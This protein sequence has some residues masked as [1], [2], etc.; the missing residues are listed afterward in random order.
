MKHLMV[1]LETLGT[2]ADAVICS[3]GAVKFDLET[4]AVADDGFYASIDVSSNLDLGRRINEDTLLWWFKQPANAQAVMFEDKISLVPALEEFSD[5]IGADDMVVWAK[6]PSFDI[7]MIEHA[8]KQAKIEVPWKF[9]NTR[10][11]RTYEDLPGAKAHRAQQTGVKHNALADAVTQAESIVNIHRA[12][13][14]PQTK[15][16]S[17]AP[18]KARAVK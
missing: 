12:L 6:G 7:A 4:L 9:W 5:W 14:T 16:T 13:F 15:V 10:C 2:T 3:I 18:S 17:K 8:Y 1:D 11:V